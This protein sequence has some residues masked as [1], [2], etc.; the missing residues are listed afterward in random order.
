MTRSIYYYQPS[1]ET[2]LNLGLMHLID[3]QYMKTTVFKTFLFFA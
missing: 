2:E 1:G 3:E